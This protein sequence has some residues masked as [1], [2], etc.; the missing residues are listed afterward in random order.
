MSGLIR[1][2]MSAACR[3][4]TW[5]AAGP[6]ADTEARRHGGELT[7]GPKPPHPTVVTASPTYFKENQ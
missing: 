2:E 7:G 6:D 4:C 1:L 5:T 3:R